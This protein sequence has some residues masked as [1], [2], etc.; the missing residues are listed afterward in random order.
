MEILVFIFLSFILLLDLAFHQIPGYSYRC[1]SSNSLS[2]DCASIS[3]CDV[4]SIEMV[5]PQGC[6]EC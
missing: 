2:D 1:R 5:L 3:Y 4:S 6:P